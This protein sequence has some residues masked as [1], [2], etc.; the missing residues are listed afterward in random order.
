MVV[1][2]TAAEGIA[3]DAE[4]VDGWEESV[5][6]FARG[7]LGL[8]RLLPFAP[9]LR[10][11][12]A[13]LPNVEGVAALEGGLLGLL[14]AGLS[15][16]EKKSSSLVGVA[17]PSVVDTAATISVTTTSSGYLYAHKPLYHADMV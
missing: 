3:R 8:D 5:S 4:L 7:D 14:I 9:G 16:E 10:N 11:G 17:V 12:E 2:R 6:A 13:V 1:F 15:H